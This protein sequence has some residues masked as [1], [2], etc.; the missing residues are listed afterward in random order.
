MARARAVIVHDGAVALI[1]RRRGGRRYVVVP[2]GGVEAGE[3]PR[4]AAAREATEELGLLVEVG[5]LIASVAI[6][7]DV[8][9]FFLATV[10][11]GEFGTG[12]GREM[13]GRGRPAA[14]S[15][16]P[17][18]VPIDDLPDLPIVPG[19]VVDALVAAAREG[20]VRNVAVLRDE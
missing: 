17:V 19:C 3:S 2:G 10:V 4:Q 15:Y 12:Q 14:G 6:A 20:A 13:T 7:G 16:R 18:W 11:G 1:E 8:Q 5:D 9:H